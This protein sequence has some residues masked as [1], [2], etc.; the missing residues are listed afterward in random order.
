MPLSVERIGKKLKGE[1]NE[2]TLYRALEALADKQ[3]IRRVDLGHGHAH[4][5]MEKHHHHHLICTDC[6]TVEDVAI[7]PLPQ[8]ERSK[9]FASIYSHSVEFFGL[10]L[11]CS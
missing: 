7:C 4:Y 11:H 5:E 9:K 3:I 6:G 2:V 1:A 8:L 10:C